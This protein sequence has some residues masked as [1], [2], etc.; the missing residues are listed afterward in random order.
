MQQVQDEKS[1]DICKIDAC[2]MRKRGSH[3]NANGDDSVG[4]EK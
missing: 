1:L 4:A 2:D 3:S